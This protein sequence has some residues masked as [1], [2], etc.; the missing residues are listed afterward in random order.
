M[1]E[2]EIMARAVSLKHAGQYDEARTL[3]R[4]VIDYIPQCDPA[5]KGL[6]KLEIGTGHFKDAIRATLMKIDLG[7]YFTRQVPQ[8]QFL[9]ICRGAL[10]NLDTT[11]FTPEIRFGKTIIPRDETYKQSV[12]SPNVGAVALLAWAETDVYYYLGHCLVRLFP[13]AFA[14]YAI[15]DSYLKN[16]ENAV[17][18]HPSGLDARDTKYAPVFYISGFWFAVSNIRSPLATIEPAIL[19]A[20]FNRQLNFMGLDELA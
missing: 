15:P 13:R 10:Q 9:F 8:Q 18:G 3:Y 4:S 12:S 14:H 16:F 6:S 20:R 5:Y 7:I 11:L 17:L 19:K 1:N 2:Q